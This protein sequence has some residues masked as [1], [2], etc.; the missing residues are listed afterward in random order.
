[1]TGRVALA[2]AV[3]VIANLQF[4]VSFP[5]CFICIVDRTS[6]VQSFCDSSKPVSAPLRICTR[7]DIWLLD[8]NLV[9]HIL[10][11][12]CFASFVDILSGPNMHATRPPVPVPIM[13]SK[14]SETLTLPGSRLFSNSYW[15]RMSSTTCIWVSGPRFS[16]LPPSR[17]KSATPDFSSF[18]MMVE[19][20]Q[21][22]A[23]LS[24]IALIV[25]TTEGLF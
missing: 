13:K 25:V 18:D 4:G 8:Q 5:T 1:M 21:S 15:S 6:S 3:A 24:P 9:F 7:S 14:I 20:Q 12:A 16:H 23:I 10:R 22:E 2:V 11:Y 19:Q 17:D